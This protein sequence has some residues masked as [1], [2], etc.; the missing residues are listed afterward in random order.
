MEKLLLGGKAKPKTINLNVEPKTVR[1]SQANITVTYILV[2][3]TS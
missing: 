1:L 3:E 2:S